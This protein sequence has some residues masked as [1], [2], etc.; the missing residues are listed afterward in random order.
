[1]IQTGIF[2]MKRK[3]S[4]RLPNATFGTGEVEVID[5]EAVTFFQGQSGNEYVTSDDNEVEI[6]EATTLLPKSSSLSVGN[7]MKCNTGEEVEILH[8]STVNALNVYTHPRFLCALYPFTATTNSKNSA[9]RTTASNQLHCPKCFCCICQ[10]EVSKCKNWKIHCNA[11]GVTAKKP[12]HTPWTTQEVI[13]VDKE[14]ESSDSEGEYDHETTSESEAGTTQSSSGSDGEYET[15]SDSEDGSSVQPKTTSKKVHK[16]SGGNNC[17]SS[18][19]TNNSKTLKAQTSDSP[20]VMGETALSAKGNSSSKH[21]T[22]LTKTKAISNKQETSSTTTKTK[23]NEP[24]VKKDSIERISK[25]KRLPKPNTPSNTSPKAK[26]NSNVKG[27]QSNSSK[28]KRS[29][30]TT[31]KQSDKQLAKKGNTAASKKRRKISNA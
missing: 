22:S 3:K 23:S 11:K 26:I 7:V 13:D 28:K 24:P 6:I 31:K 1:V 14:D 8:C 10:I 27:K 29:S 4:K 18:K 12:K 17:I 2:I 20:A 30:T 9:S 16:T 5:V 15:T 21:D 25:P 19:R